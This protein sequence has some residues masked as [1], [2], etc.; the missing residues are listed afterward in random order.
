MSSFFITALIEEQRTTT[1]E[2]HNAHYNLF[3]HNVE[4]VWHVHSSLVVV[5]VSHVWSVEKGN[6]VCLFCFL[7]HSLIVENVAKVT[8]P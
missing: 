6:L 7:Y 5:G 1:A 8:P 4:S 3:K 2:R